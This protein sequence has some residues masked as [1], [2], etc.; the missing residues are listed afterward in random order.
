MIKN[1]SLY[2]QQNPSLAIQHGRRFILCCTSFIFRGFN[3]FNSIF[4]K[5][6]VENGI[7]R[8][9]WYFKFLKIFFTFE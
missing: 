8:G 1:F 2:L 7:G 6:P 3:F 4:A 9:H 5:K